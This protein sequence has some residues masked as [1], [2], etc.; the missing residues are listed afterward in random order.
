MKQNTTCQNS[1]LILP[2]SEGAWAADAAA[3]PCVPWQRHYWSL[4]G[5][6]ARVYM[7]S[8]SVSAS[9]GVLSVHALCCSLQHLCD[10]EAVRH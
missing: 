6:R 2:S 8:M 1:V 3:M 10:G 7:Y 4:L 9:P 5:W